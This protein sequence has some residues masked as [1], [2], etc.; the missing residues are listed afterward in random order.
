MLKLL[1]ISGELSTGLFL[2]V[3]N[4]S[5]S[6][7]WLVIAVVLLRFALKKA[8]K[9]THVL[10]WSM[11]ALRLICPFT[12]ESALSLIPSAQTVSPE[13]MLSPT[14]SV[15]TGVE[16]VNDVVNPMIQSTFA[17]NPATSANPLQILIPVASALWLLGMGIM[18]MYL[19]VSYVLLRRKVSSA[20]C[21]NQ[22]IY[23]CGAVDSPFILGIVR[24]RIYLPVTIQERDIP[25]VLS[26]ERAHLRR[27]DHW[28]KPLGYLILTLHWFNPGVWLAYWLLCRDIELACDEKVIRELGRQRQADYSQALLNCS[29]HRRS[30]ASCPLA[31]GEVGVKQRVRNILNYKKPAFWVIL[32]ALVVCAVVAVCFLTN[33][34]T[35]EAPFG[36]DWYI[37]E[38]LYTADFGS[39]DIGS[40]PLD[41]YPYEVTTIDHVLLR[42]QYRLDRNGDFSAL[43]S[44]TGKWAKLGTFREYHLSMVNFDE[45]FKSESQWHTRLYRPEKLRETCVRVWRLDVNSTFPGRFYLL[46]EQEDG[47]YYLFCGYDEKTSH[48]ANEDGSVMYWAAKLTGTPNFSPSVTQWYDYLENNSY[49]ES[50]DDNQAQLPQFP[51]VTFHGEPEAVYAASFGTKTAIITG[52]PVWNVYLCDLTG[53]GIPDFCSTVSYGSGI[54]DEH[55]VVYDYAT[56]TEYTLWD[57]GNY[58]YTLCM[59]ND[60][61]I[62]EKWLYPHSGLVE[63]GELMLVRAVGG[64]GARLEIYVEEEKEPKG[65]VSF[66]NVDFSNVTSIK[67][68]N[69]HN[70]NNTFLFDSEK[71]QAICAWLSTVSG[72][73]ARNS[74]GWHYQG[75]YALTLMAGDEEVFSIGFGDDPVIFYGMYDDRYAM[76]YDL[77]RITID[78]AVRFL[79]R[80]D[81]SDFDWGFEETAVSVEIPPYEITSNIPYEELKGDIEYLQPG[82]VIGYGFLREELRELGILL[83]NLMPEAFVT[84]VDYTPTMKVNLSWPGGKLTLYSDGTQT[85]IGGDGEWAVRTEDLNRFLSRFHPEKFTEGE[86]VPLEDINPY[87]NSEQATIDGCVVFRNSDIRDNAEYFTA[88]VDTVSHGAPI[89]VR[90]AWFSDEARFAVGVTDVIFDGE[91]FTWRTSSDG[92]ITE[93][94]YQYLRH[95]SGEPTEPNAAYDAYDAYILTNDRTA[96][97][98]QLWN[99]LYSSQPDAAIDFSIVYMDYIY[100]PDHPQIP[101]CEAITLELDGEVLLTVADTDALEALLSGAE[102]TYEPKTYLSGPVLRMHGKDGSEMMVTLSLDTDWIVI[103]GLYY[104]F[105]PGYVE[106]GSRNALPDLFAL[107]GIDNWP[108]EVMDAYPDFF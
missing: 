29:I 19:L 24:P 61:L 73:N 100:Y 44:D 62:C 80:F 58:D 39:A 53:D 77:D 2:K 93:K 69:A 60:K 48:A 32:V 12:M 68:S 82:D 94:R 103:D 84:P 71:I 23:Q 16:A 27:R 76:M 17:P 36:Q 105:G 56:G 11:V 28:W 18:L 51:D 50:I 107:L 59:E 95:F 49:P 1:L 10:L 74:K 83:N 98:E 106:D 40:I 35:A 78:E 52:M 47:Y 42:V 54:I 13:I 46:T 85:V 108:R 81:D 25:H 7:L 41:A 38:F 20:V 8:P 57:R 55:V 34:V 88:F 72:S 102:L 79:C 86:Q 26:H 65:S 4:M 30:I 31:F 33:P 21:L 91:G 22:N 67:L 75:T 37:Q 63:R 14:P 101:D 45:Y 6:A 70:G 99:S 96:T 97:W 90:T 87:Y 92:V 9:W 5:I 43:E 3:L 89:A 64:N 104:D 66:R 15:D